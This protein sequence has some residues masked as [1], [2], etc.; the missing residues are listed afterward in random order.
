ME[1]LVKKYCFRV[2][3]LDVEEEFVDGRERGTAAE[4]R[5]DAT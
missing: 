1:L 3:Q 4:E 5:R 2:P